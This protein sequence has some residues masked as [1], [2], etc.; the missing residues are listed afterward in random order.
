MN[1]SNPSEY[2][3]AVVDND[4]TDDRMDQIRQLLIGDFQKAQDARVLAL[5]ARVREIETIM[6]RRLDALQARIDALSGEVTTNQR[7]AFDEMSRG[8]KE[9]SDRIRQIPRD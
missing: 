9:L 8:V 5:E 1:A 6:V 4:P 7:T 3:T 2:R